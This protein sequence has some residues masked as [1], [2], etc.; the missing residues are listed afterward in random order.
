MSAG[1]SGLYP[2]S[3][4]SNSVFL[5]EAIH[6]RLYCVVL[7][8]YLQQG[9]LQTILFHGSGGKSSVRAVSIR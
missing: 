2:G 9:S 3:R 7:T 4:L 6:A 8:G 1:V 5:V